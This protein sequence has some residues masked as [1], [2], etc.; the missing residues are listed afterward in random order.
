MSAKFGPAGCPESFYAAGHKSTIE[1]PEWLNSIGLGAFEVQCGRGVK[2]SDE[3]AR[4]IGENAKHFGVQLSV[5]SPYYINI[6]TTD[7][8]K[9]EG[10]LNYVLQTLHVAKIMCAKRIVVHM[11][12]F[13]GST[14]EAALGVSKDFMRLCLK[15]TDDI[16]ICPETMGKMNQMGTVDE[17]LELCSIDERLMP[18]LDFGHINSRGQGCLRNEE[19]FEKIF[20]KYENILGRE[21]L[22]KFHAHF[23]KI[24][25]TKGG[26]K[27]HLTFA[28]TVYGPEFEPLAR[29]IVK[30]GLEPVI[31]CESDGTQ[32]EDALV[33]KKLYEE[34]VG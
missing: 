24:E 25:F 3:S 19:D 27:R 4:R 11:G 10:S 21:R 14:R 26:E 8:E 7:P 5:H 31:I 32:A 34:A 16:I 33:M 9:Q 17:V 6:S 13:A 22:N 2:F 28:D 20:E 12:S 23:S 29:V 15:H 30:R 1:M 18:T